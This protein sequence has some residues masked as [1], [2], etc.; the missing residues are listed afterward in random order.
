MRHERAQR[1][2]TTVRFHTLSIAGELTLSTQQY[3]SGVPE[4]FDRLISGYRLTPTAL[5]RD[6][7]LP[8]PPNDEIPPH[9]DRLVSGYHL[10]QT[11]LY[12]DTASFRPSYIGIP[13]YSDRLIGRSPPR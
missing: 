11:A 5:N 1:G 10:T 12:R 6:N 8:R 9:S 7:A 3:G 2:Y 4:Q 13:P